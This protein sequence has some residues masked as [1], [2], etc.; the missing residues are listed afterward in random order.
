MRKIKAYFKEKNTFN[1]YD[2][3]DITNVKEVHYFNKETKIF[4]TAREYE[5]EE[6][7]YLVS[8]Y[9]SSFESDYLSHKMEFGTIL[10][11]NE[12]IELIFNSINTED[13]AKS[14][15]WYELDWFQY[16]KGIDY[17]CLKENKVTK[18][19]AESMFEGNPFIRDCSYK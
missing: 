5:I 17:L 12:Y 2:S 18:S 11:K 10:D 13:L 9:W 6:Y 1:F 8:F 19:M 16:R 14:N 15:K 7:G 4:I 3:Y